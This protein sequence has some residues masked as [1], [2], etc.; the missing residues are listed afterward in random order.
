MRSVHSRQSRHFSAFTLVEMLLGLMIF[1]MVSVGIYGVLGGALRLEKR[2]RGVH[3]HCEDVRQVFDLVDQDLENMIAY[4]FQKGRSDHL[5]FDGRADRMVFFLPTDEGVRQIEYYAG[6]FDPGLREEV[7]FRRVK[8]GREIFEDDGGDK[9]KQ[10]FFLRRSVPLGMILA[11][12]DD[13]G[14]IG[15][16]AGGLKREG[17]RF[18]YGVLSKDK[19]GEKEVVFQDEWKDNSLPDVIRIEIGLEDAGRTPLRRDFFPVVKG[20][21][22]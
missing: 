5:A 14:D 7:R 21:L 3:A 1:A 13:Q 20:P 8:N 4:P 16:L 6:A 18:H 12:R 15:V 10:T 9:E 19:F 22:I 11:G 2:V 17:I